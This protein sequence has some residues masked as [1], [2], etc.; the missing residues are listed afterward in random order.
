MG[1]SNLTNP[2]GTR[3]SDWTALRRELSAALHD[4]TAAREALED[5][6]ELVNDP[7]IVAGLR[8]AAGDTKAA[9][10]RVRNLTQWARG[11]R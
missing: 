6:L 7:M 1:T 11:A 3:Q 10:R 4:L 8:F 5:A 9:A 2:A